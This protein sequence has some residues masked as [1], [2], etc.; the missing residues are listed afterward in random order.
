MP[1]Q[2]QDIDIYKKCNIQTELLLIMRLTQISRVDH[3]ANL[4]RKKKNIRIFDSRP[5]DIVRL[6]SYQRNNN[7]IMVVLNFRVS[8]I[9][10]QCT[11]IR[12]RWESAE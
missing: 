3:I 5:T 2:L 4:G 8:V 9:K 1:R 10:H 6:F 7:V 12:A 11:G